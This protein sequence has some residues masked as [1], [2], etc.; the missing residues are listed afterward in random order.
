MILIIG[1]AYQGKLDFA[2]DEFNI[3]E[4][5]IF[6]CKDEN[7]NIDFNKKII[8]N[9]DKFIFSMIKNG[10]DPILYIKDNL[11]KFNDKIVTCEDISCGVVPIDYELRILRESIGHC[12]A[13]LSKN[14][15]R[16]VRLF[17]GIPMELK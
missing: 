8:A 16:V 12:L 3:N 15:D 13:I 2:K 11:E 1:G 9:I 5:D 6:Y 10:K 14:S 4:Q 17:C 7:V